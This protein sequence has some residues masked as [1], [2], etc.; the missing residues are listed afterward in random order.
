MS[1]NIYLYI[2]LSILVLLM[3]GAIIYFVILMKDRQGSS[4][5]NQNS[6]ATLNSNSANSNVN[7][8]QT[9]WTEE[10]I[11]TTVKTT[12]ERTELVEG[13]T[14]TFDVAISS[15]ENFPNA[16]LQI[17][18]I[19]SSSGFDA[20]SSTK[21]VNLEEDKTTTESFALPLPYCTSCSG[22]SEG[23]HTVY[24]NIVSGQILIGKNQFDIVLK[25][26]T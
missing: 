8:S 12:A 2:L 10:N 25:K 3:A 14:L 23:S 11:E 20:L 21:P 19:K 6:T 9:T 5:S 13:E 16:Q 26:K 22:V 7:G 4:V 1:R 17:S 15:Q 24:I 18:G